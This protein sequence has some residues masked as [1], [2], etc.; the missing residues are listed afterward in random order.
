[1]DEKEYEL[2][3]VRYCGF[4]KRIKLRLL[5]ISYEYKQPKGNKSAP[6]ELCVN[7]KKVKR[8]LKATSEVLESLPD[9]E[10][11]TVRAYREQI[12]ESVGE[13]RYPLWYKALLIEREYDSALRELTEERARSNGLFDTES[14]PYREEAKRISYA[15]LIAYSELETNNEARERAV[16]ELGRFDSK[17]RKLLCRLMWWIYSDEARGVLLSAVSAAEDSILRTMAE[18][19]GLEE[20]LYSITQKISECEGR[21]AVSMSEFDAREEDLARRRTDRLGMLK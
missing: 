16:E 4:T 5:E 15:L 8:V 14:A 7:R 21:R 1:M 10:D 12:A 18:I 19:R 3:G 2:L 9:H 17:R 6:F 11:E 13:K 20:E